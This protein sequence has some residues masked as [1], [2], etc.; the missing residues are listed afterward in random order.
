MAA[1]YGLMGQVAAA[2]GALI[3]ALVLALG[4]LRLR[5]SPTFSAALVWAFI[6]IVVQNLD[7]SVFVLSL[8]IAGALAVAVATLLPGS[9]KQRPT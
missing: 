7:G 6:G 5:R 4:V 2:A 1:G 8:A 3:L 9:G